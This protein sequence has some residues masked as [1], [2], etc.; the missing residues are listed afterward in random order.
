LARQNA[1]FTQTEQEVHWQ[2]CPYTFSK[3]LA[4]ITIA[5]NFYKRQND[6]IVTHTDGGLAFVSVNDGHGCAYAY[7][8]GRSECKFALEKSERKKVIK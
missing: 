1:I 7:S 4:K 5:R 3:K 8:Q 2:V 6:C